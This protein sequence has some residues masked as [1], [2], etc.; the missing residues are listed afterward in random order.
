VAYVASA[1]GSPV[2]PLLDQPT[3]TA[4]QWRQVRDWWTSYVDDRVM[5]ETWLRRLDYYHLVRLR[6]ELDWD[7]WLVSFLFRTDL[8]MSGP[9]FADP[10]GR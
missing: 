6:A 4:E 3:L 5:Q 9:P 8:Y 10:R 7:R 1:L 2:R